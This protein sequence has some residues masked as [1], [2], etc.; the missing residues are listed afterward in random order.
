M[1]AGGVEDGNNDAMRANPR[2]HQLI[3]SPVS[4]PKRAMRS[5]TRDDDPRYTVGLYSTRKRFTEKA[6]VAQVDALDDPR[7]TQTMA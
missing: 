5:P 7:H 1:E 3:S 6:E 2:V 4:R